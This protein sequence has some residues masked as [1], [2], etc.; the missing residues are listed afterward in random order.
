MELTSQQQIERAEHARRIVEDD[1]FKEAALAV[2]QDILTRW[3]GALDLEVREKCHAEHRVLQA[4]LIKFREAIANGEIVKEREK[5]RK[6]RE[7]EI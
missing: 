1:L 4:F 3:K 7:K 5:Q 6:R 2:E